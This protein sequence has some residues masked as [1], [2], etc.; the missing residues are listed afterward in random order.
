MSLSFSQVKSPVAVERRVDRLQER[1][2]AVCQTVTDMKDSG[3]PI[4]VSGDPLTLVAVQNMANSGALIQTTWNNSSSKRGG[5]LYEVKSRAQHRTDIN[6]PSWVPDGYGDH[7]LFNGT[8]YVAVIIIG[9]SVMVETFGA[10]PDYN[11]STGAGTDN[12]AVFS[13]VRDYVD[14]DE[15]ISIVTINTGKFRGRIHSNGADNQTWKLSE[16]TIIAQGNGDILNAF[17]ITNSTKFVVEGGKST[18]FARIS[19]LINCSDSNFCG[20]K[21]HTAYFATKSTYSG[22]AIYDK[23]GFF[24]ENDVRCFVVD[25]EVYNIEGFGISCTQVGSANLFQRN[26]IHDNVGGILNNGNTNNFN[27]FMDNDIGFNNV[28]GG[29]GNDGILINASS[30]DTSS[31]GH[32]ITGNRIYNSGEHGTYIQCANSL[33]SN[34]R[35]YS[36]AECGIKMAKV[37]NMQCTNNVIWD[38]ESS[39]QVQSGYEDVLVEGNTCRLATGTFDLDFTWNT[40]LDSQ[41]G[42]NVKVIGNYFMS[43]VANWSAD[44]DGIEGIIFEGNTCA[45]GLIYSGNATAPYTRVDIKNNEFQDGLLRIINTSGAVVRGNRMKNLWCTNANSGVIFEDNVISALNIGTRKDVELDAF[46][47]FCRNK[48][49]STD[50]GGAPNYELINGQDAVVD[51]LRFCDNEII[52]GGAIIVNVNT[53]GGVTNSIFANNIFSGGDVNITTASSNNVFSGNVGMSG[54]ITS[55]NSVGT[56]NTGGATFSGTGSTYANNI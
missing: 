8:D 13:A 12:T 16:N 42:K 54:T 33:I 5:A 28:S 4:V 52:S 46:K 18:S 36:N 26:Y 17:S 47:S 19:R 1:V 30:V 50:A 11:E 34:N 31:S 38:N 51:K 37:R 44:I 2:A 39:I 45:K 23:A 24:M 10:I 32:T 6:N 3:G 25:C 22:A 56:C 53:S 20:F 43:D 40:G 9:N 29:S 49:I 41:G 55:T 7:Y 21:K 48:I 35:V 14:S 27:R 15:N